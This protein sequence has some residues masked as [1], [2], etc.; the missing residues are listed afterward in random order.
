[1]LAPGTEPSE[2][3]KAWI[4][5]QDE[6]VERALAEFRDKYGVSDLFLDRLAEAR[7][8]ELRRRPQ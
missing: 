8:E 3:R 7:M 5:L 6:R 1:M 4:A 2:A